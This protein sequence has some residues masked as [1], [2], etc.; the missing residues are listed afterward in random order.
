MFYLTLC[1]IYYAFIAKVLIDL[2]YVTSQSLRIRAL[3]FWGGGQ[4]VGVKKKQHFCSRRKTG[5]HVIKMYSY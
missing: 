3:I 5:L 4:I 1:H 2:L